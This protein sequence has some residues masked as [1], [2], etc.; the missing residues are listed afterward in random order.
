MLNA[1][2]LKRRKLM[3]HIH[4][5]NASIWRLRLFANTLAYYPLHVEC[6]TLAMLQLINIIKKKPTHKS[7]AGLLSCEYYLYSVRS[8]ISGNSNTSR[9]EG[10]LVSSMTNRSMPIPNPP[11]G[12]KPNS[13]ARM[14]SSSII[15][16]SSL[17][18]SRS[19]S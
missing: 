16:A 10:E 4:T 7:S 12:G 9:I 15:W 1:S 18:C 13:N 8:R 5:G 19:F 11:V 2:L 14:K 17:P 6:A 3:Y